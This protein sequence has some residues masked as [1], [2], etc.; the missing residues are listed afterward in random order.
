MPAFR[1]CKL[2]HRPLAASPPS[3]STQLPS[4]STSRELRTDAHHAV[5]TMADSQS[6]A[7]AELVEK[8]GYQQPVMPQ[9]MYIFK[10]PRIGA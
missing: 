1:E 2:T 5:R 3:R 7:V 10:Q 8:L 9:S 4:P 6:K